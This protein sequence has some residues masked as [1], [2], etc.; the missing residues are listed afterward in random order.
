MVNCVYSQLSLPASPTLA[1]RLK[2]FDLLRRVDWEIITGHPGI[3]GNYLP[4]ST[5]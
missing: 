4:G 2:S 1:G 5:A 3:A